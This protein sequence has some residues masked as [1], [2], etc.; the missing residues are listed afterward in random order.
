M[1]DLPRTEKIY[2]ANIRDSGWGGGNN[3]GSIVRAVP[4]IANL[5]TGIAEV[6]AMRDGFRIRFTRPVDGKLATAVDKYSVSSYRRKST[7]A[8]GGDDMDR[9]RESVLAVAVARD[10]MSVDLRLNKLRAG[11]V[12]EFRLKKLIPTGSRFYPAEAFYTLRR[13]NK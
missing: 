12:Y 4:D 8:Y 3:K 9:R 10:L 5:P 11:F 6:T 13:L 2:V 7:P 1:C